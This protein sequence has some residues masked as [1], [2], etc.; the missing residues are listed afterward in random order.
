MQTDDA[1]AA[2]TARLAGHQ[3]GS[4]LQTVLPTAEAGLHVARHALEDDGAD[5]DKGPVVQRGGE[6]A[7][8]VS[9]HK[10]RAKGETLAARECADDAFQTTTVSIISKRVAGE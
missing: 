6:D 8:L 9:E 10:G 2:A 3:S 4:G 5:G 1:Q 7:V